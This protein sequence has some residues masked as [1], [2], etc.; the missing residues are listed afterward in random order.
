MVYDREYY[1]LKQKTSM[2]QQTQ[3]QSIEQLSQAEINPDDYLRTVI[4]LYRQDEADYRG[5]R[6][7]DQEVIAE[8]ASQEA[9]EHFDAVFLSVFA[10]T[11]VLRPGVADTFVPPTEDDERDVTLGNLKDG[12]SLKDMRNAWRQLWAGLSI[13][14][15][16]LKRDS[17]AFEQTGYPE[18]FEMSEENKSRVIGK[19]FSNF[20]DLNALRF[21]V[22]GSG[23]RRTHRQHNDDGGIDEY[24][25]DKDLALDRKR[26]TLDDR[27]V[28]ENAAR[29]GYTAKRD[30]SQALGAIHP[31]GKMYPEE[32]VGLR[33]KFAEVDMDDFAQDVAFLKDVAKYYNREDEEA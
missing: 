26:K 5:R 6:N 32:F 8:I 10:L 2:D 11:K 7:E 12:A 15:H 19:L 30:K 16:R 14:T 21:G 23:V 18:L 9:D 25:Y 1:I 17:Q 22:R 28:A 3:N 24:T 31:A 27:K 4:D 20:Q 13:L 33:K 29:R